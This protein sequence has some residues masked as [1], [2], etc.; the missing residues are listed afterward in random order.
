MDL[1]KKV[2]EMETLS[3]KVVVVIDDTI[4]FLLHFRFTSNTRASRKY[5][6]VLH[7]SMVDE[8]HR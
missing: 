6:F 3:A 1:D 5:L 4:N 7:R 8:R 2:V